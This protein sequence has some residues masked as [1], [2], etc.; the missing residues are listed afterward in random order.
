VHPA[1]ICD[2]GCEPRTV[3]PVS[4]KAC[5]ALNDRWLILC[6]PVQEVAAATNDLQP[7]PN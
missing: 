7:T 4:G 6:K 1:V 5:R 2:D 3:I